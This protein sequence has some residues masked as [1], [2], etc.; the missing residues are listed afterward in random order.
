MSLKIAGNLLKQS[1]FLPLFVLFQAGTFNDNALK[2]ALIALV[3]S[4]AGGQMEQAAGALR[5]LGY[6]NASYQVAIASAGGIPP[7]M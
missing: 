6:N 2:N 7:L 4:G 3:T 5:N 1:R